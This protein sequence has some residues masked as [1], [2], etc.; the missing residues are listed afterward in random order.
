MF[1]GH[2][3]EWRRGVG[4]GQQVVELALRM[5]CND[6]G[7]D[8]SEVSVRVDAVE[9]GGFYERSDGRPVLATTVGTGEERI[10]SI[11]GDWSDRAFDDV[12]VDLDAAIIEESTKSSPARQWVADCFGELA[13]LADQGELLAQP[14][15]EGIDDGAAS[16]LARGAPFFGRASPYLALDLVEL[17]DALE[18]L[19]GNWRRPGLRQFVE[20]STHMRP[21]EGQAHGIALGQRPVSGVAVDLQDSDEALKVAQWLFS[22]AVGCIEIGDARWSDPAPGPVVTHVGEQLAGLR[23]PPA[24]IEHRRSRLVGEELVGCLQPLKQP[25]VDR[26]KQECCLADPVGERSKFTPWRA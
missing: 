2:G 21:A 17:G 25:L 12:G 20:A 3:L 18:R 10:L 13:L 9:L 26:P 5:A 8:V 23:P 11:E 22:L 24:R 16:L 14:W 6:A 15:L 4:P 7:D 19:R 1:S